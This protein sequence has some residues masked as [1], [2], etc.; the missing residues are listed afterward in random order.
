[1]LLLYWSIAAGVLSFGNYLYW[2]IFPDKE[3]ETNNLKNS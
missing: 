1:M 3:D 2:S